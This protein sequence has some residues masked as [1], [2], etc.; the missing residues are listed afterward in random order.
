MIRLSSK[1]YEKNTRPRKG[2]S[3][4]RSLRSA[5]R[6]RGRTA[7]LEIRAVYLLT[8]TD[9]SNGISP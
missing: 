2:G 1:N 6:G 9:A 7:F 4:K 3:P 5:G 8:N